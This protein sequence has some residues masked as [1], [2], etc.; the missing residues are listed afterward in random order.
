MEVCFQALVFMA[1]REDQAPGR[2]SECF[3]GIEDLERV[4]VLWCVGFEL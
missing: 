2:G 4:R 1:S 3:D